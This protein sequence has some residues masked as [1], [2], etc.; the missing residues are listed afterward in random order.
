MENLFSVVVPTRNRG[1]ISECLLMILQQS[2]RPLELVVVDQ[3]TDSGTKECV[4]RVI[5]DHAE[6]GNKIVYVPTDQT[7]LSNARNL[8]VSKSK[9]EWIAFV[10]DDV[11]VTHEWAERLVEEYK[12]D[13]KLGMVFGQTRAYY[14][15]DGD[16]RI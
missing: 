6:D 8:G 12:K 5:R 10:D 7:G 13:P 1:D 11:L 4:E 9:G 14:K 3:S 2:Y 15:P 16:K